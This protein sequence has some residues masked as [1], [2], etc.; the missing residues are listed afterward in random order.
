MLIAAIVIVVVVF[1]LMW[2]LALCAAAG[3]ADRMM[4]EMENCGPDPPRAF[5]ELRCPG[6]PP[7]FCEICHKRETCCFWTM[8]ARG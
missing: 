1:L 7:V 8:S 2:G 5:I 3:R 4:E 6:Q